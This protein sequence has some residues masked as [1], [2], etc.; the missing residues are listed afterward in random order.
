[1][2]CGNPIE[3]AELKGDETVLD[4][5]CGI[6][7]DVFLAA[8]KFL[9]KG[10]VIGL[11][12]NPERIQT[13]REK[14]TESHYTNVE[15]CVGTVENLPFD[16]SSIDVVISNCVINYSIDKLAVFKEIR[17]ILKSKGRFIISDLVIEGSF[18]ESVK[19][20][21]VWGE[22]ITGAIGKADYLKAIHKAGFR[23]VSILSESTFPMVEED[24]R[25]KG[26]IISLTIRGFK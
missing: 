17:R 18:S 9:D 14:A 10:R 26:K 21:K 19:Q 24:E 11:D 3:L 23:K 13:A 6:G 12:K 7:S 22:W 4:L 20:D 25:L 1:M 15:F 2:G 8:D 5:G 16:N